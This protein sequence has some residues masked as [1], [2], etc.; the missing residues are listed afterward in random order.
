MPI[1]LWRTILLAI[2]LVGARFGGAAIAL[3]SQILLA[4]LLTQTDVGVVFVGIEC[5]SIHQ[6]AD[7]R[8][9][10]DLGNYLFA[11]LLR[12]WPRKFGARLSRRIFA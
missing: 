4:R 6:S 3:A 12:P 10:S 5:G 1:S 8:W 2:N 7:N 9:L 11:P